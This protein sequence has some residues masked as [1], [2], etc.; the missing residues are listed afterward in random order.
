VEALR[1]NDPMTRHTLNFQHLY[2]KALRTHL[3]QGRRAG[4]ESAKGLG[5]QALA[6]GLPTLDLA[7][8]HEK[9]LIMDLLPS[10]PVGRRSSLIKQAGTFFAAATAP[11]SKADYNTKEAL[12]VKKIIGALSDRTVELASANL[13]LSAEISNRRKAE[14]S[15]KRSERHNLKSLE[16]SNILKDQLRAL[17]RQ[18]LSIQ[19]EERKKISRELHDVVAQ[20][21]MGINVRLANLKTEAGNNTKGLSRS[22]NRTQKMVT[23][24]ANIVHQFALELRPTALDDL[25]LIPALQSYMKSFMTQTGIRTHLTA[26]AGVEKLDSARRTVLY[27]VAQEALTNVGRHAHAHRVEVTIRKEAKL[28][29]LEISDDGKS[30]D[31]SSVLLARGKK[32]LGLLGMRERVEMV[33]GT[34]N[35]DSVAGRG[36]NIIARIPITKTIVKKWGAES[37]G[38]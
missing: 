22:I 25:G 1:T 3:E 32:H 17:S 29:H 35:V 4:I 33:G 18:I 2:Q 8:L 27:R 13:Q 23:K 26:F 19:E 10:Y 21:L 28:V 9:T 20:A 31:V 5:I 12:R 11:V 38:N 37:A 16:E 36:T 7:K 34:F 6:A 30:F 24:S 14:G 15:L